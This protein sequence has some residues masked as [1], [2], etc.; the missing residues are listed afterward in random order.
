MYYIYAVCILKGGVSIIVYYNDAHSSLQ[1]TTY[2]CVSYK[3][4]TWVCIQ[5]ILFERYVIQWKMPPDL[6]TYLIIAVDAHCHLILIHDLVL[7]DIPERIVAT[8]RV[9]SDVYTRTPP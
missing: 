5:C 8:T 9:S 3:Y 7:R 4:L 1:D 2:Q 6:P